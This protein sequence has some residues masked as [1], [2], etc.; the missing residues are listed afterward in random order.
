MTNTRMA[1]RSKVK[2]YTAVEKDLSIGSL[3]LQRKLTK[4]TT[5]LVFSSI[6]IV[7]SNFAFG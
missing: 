3:E 5:C 1:Q 4:E 2:N 7:F 6:F